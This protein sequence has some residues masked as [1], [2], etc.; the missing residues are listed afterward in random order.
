[1]PLSRAIPWGLFVLSLTGVT[2]A[3]PV[4]ARDPVD[5]AISTRAVLIPQPKRVAYRDDLFEIV[6]GADIATDRSNLATAQYLQRELHRLYAV[7]CGVVEVAATANRGSGIVLKDAATGGEVP[8]NPE[9]YTLSVDKNRVLVT[10][11]GAAGAFYGVQTL[12]QLLQQTAAGTVARSCEIRDEPALAWRGVYLNLRNIDREPASIQALKDLLNAFA[13]MKMNTLFIEI[14]DNLQ[15]DRQS[16]PLAA[17]QALSKAQ[18]TDLVDYAKSLHFE[19]IPTLQ[20]LSHTMWMLTNPQ[21]SELLE[22]SPAAGWNMAWCPSNSAVDTL[23]KDMLEETVEIFR[24]RYF[25]IGMDE[26]NDGPF[27]ECPECRKKN[28]SE[29]FLG[30]I[31]RMHDL[32]AA[33]GVRTIMWHDTLLPREAF[34]DKVQGWKIVDRLP[35]DIIV[36]DWDYGVYDQAAQERLRYFTGRGFQVLGATFCSPK[37]IQTFAAG[38]SR[39][40]G[41]LGL[42]DTL[43]VYV[44]AWT[45]PET[46]AP[47]AWAAVTLTAQYAWNPRTPKLTEIAY[48][49]VYELAR[50]L[51]P[52]SPGTGKWSPVPLTECFNYR[53]SD[54]ADSWPGYG[55]GNTLEQVFAGDISCG[56][57]TF[58]MAGEAAAN[59]VILLSAQADEALPATPVTIPLG[60]KAH[61]LAFLATCN[62]P[63][64]KDALSGFHRPTAKPVVGKYTVEFADA[65]TT[66]ILLCYKWNIVDWN[67]KFG[68]F[69]G[70]LA[71]SGETR[72]GNRLQL[73]RT[74]WL[75]PYPDKTIRNLRA[76]ASNQAGMSLAIFALSAEAVKEN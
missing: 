10:S 46:I 64:N 18:V 26:V 5:T 72:K 4:A 22:G 70:R 21:N 76:T 24:P 68:A 41:T 56:Q 1:M 66:E 69:A 52:A 23:L 35:K 62:V 43:W 42:F 61:R 3:H 47:E 59:N 37:G 44:N 60:R 29:L 6:S 7:D 39:E 71:Y 17:P 30:S 20:T 55:A 12:K 14:A 73:M 48:D 58:R 57:V 27:A 2:T 25:H 49:P 9:G 15:F 8:R 67:Y 36:A 74:D 75:N 45:K 50:M 63:L 38:L 40:A 13:S 31:L 65:T 33:Q 53:I 19:V 34:T 54:R 11:R 16:F 28:P 32:L 51:K